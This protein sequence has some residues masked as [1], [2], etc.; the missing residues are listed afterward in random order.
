MNR[1]IYFVPVPY[2]RK[3]LPD[4]EPREGEKDIDLHVD[5][6]LLDVRSCYPVKRKTP[7]PREAKMENGSKQ[8]FQYFDHHPVQIRGLWIKDRVLY[9]QYVQ[10]CNK[11]DNACVRYHI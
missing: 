4:D 10:W 8:I 5:P 9:S 2:D 1:D 6:I 3:H 7:S 11:E